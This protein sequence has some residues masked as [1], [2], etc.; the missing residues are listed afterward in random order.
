[1]EERKILIISHNPINR[2]DNMGKTIGNNFSGFSDQEL[3]Q[4][5][6]KNQNVDAQ[7]CNNFFCID[8]VSICKSIINRRYKTGKNIPNKTRVE[9]AS[10]VEENIAQYG[11]KKKRNYIYSKRFNLENRKMEHKRIKRVAK[12]TENN[13]YILISRRL[14]IPFGYCY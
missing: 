14:Y 12:F 4:L 9:K 13:F 5:Y 8:D 1:M 10:S 6:F 11:R 3:C 7:N 2:F